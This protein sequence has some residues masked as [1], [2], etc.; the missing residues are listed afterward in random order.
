MRLRGAAASACLVV[1][2]AAPAGARAAD[3]PF[4]AL[5]DRMATAWP[6]R[7]TPAGYFTDYVNGKEAH[8]YGL[9]RAGARREDARLVASGVRALDTALTKPPRS[10]GVFDT[11]TVS[12]AYNFARRELPDDPAFR[13][14]RAGWEG[15]LNS[16]PPPVLYPTIRD[17]IL[18]AVCYQNHEAVEAAGNLELLSTGLRSTIPGSKLADRDATRAAAERIVGREQPA[19]LASRA[20]STG[21]GPRGGLG[22]FPD[23]DRYPL[24]YNALSA[25]MLAHGVDAL[26]R[27]APARSRATLRRAME[28]IAAYMA[29]DG[30]VGFI[31][32]RQQQAWVLAAVAYAGQVAA[33][34][35]GGDRAAAGRYRAAAARA[36]ER[37]QRVHGFGPSGIDVVPRMRRGTRSYRGIDGA[38]NT[39]IWNGLTI[40]LL[41]QA[42]DAAREL[43]RERA[44][45]RLTADRDA[46][47]VD[48][49]AGFATVRRGALWFAVNSRPG[50]PDLRYDFGLVALKRREGG[51]PWRDLLRPRP[52]TEDAP[53][54]S[55]G[56]VVV[57]GGVRYLP[58]GESVSV[59]PDGTVRVA[60]R[61]RSP[62]GE[63]LPRSTVFAYR[64]A[65]DGVTL[66]F[67]ALAG[68]RVLLRTF[69]PA[70]GLRRGR[71]RV[72][73]RA[74]VA[75]VSPRPER[76]S[77]RTGY[78]SCCDGRLAA[79]TMQLEIPEDRS[80]SYTV[81]AR[82]AASEE[83]PAP[84]AARE[85]SGDD[86]GGSPLVPIVAALALALAALA[87][88]RQQVVRRQQRRRDAR[89]R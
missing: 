71:D 82:R 12:A 63:R 29:P 66:S 56:P 69:L 26:G 2:L 39:V 73:D 15:Y 24:A 13:A 79:A 30:D 36:V 20:S 46:H 4:A 54:D 34:E 55:A 5:A 78:A 51:E 76:I 89:L 44:A 62:E 72:L 3:E 27:R 37:L 60:G 17:C 19:A 18:S 6:P 35:A 38:N 32:R 9:M 50:L 33:V 65:R 87:L 88:R 83:E 80:V 1:V 28:S 67:R 81:Q 86:D 11:L 70:R 45:A 21:P 61:F 7:A 22:V 77:L 31:G 58:Q 14:A 64:P 49:V 43:P 10:R 40:F 84:T 75:S 48:P 47:F 42:A 23:V 41:N 59:R 53:A 8:G 16:I 57:R 68:D 25:A 85:A 52:E 74:S